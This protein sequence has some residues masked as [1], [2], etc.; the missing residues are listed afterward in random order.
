MRPTE[1]IEAWVA[2]FNAV[3]VDAA[4]DLYADDATLHVVFADKT[5]GKGA[6]RG[7][8]EMYFR[9]SDLYCE[10]RHLHAAGDTAVLEWVDRKGL[11]GCNVFRIADGQIIEQRNYFDQL[12]FFRKMGIPIPTE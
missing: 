6:I 11:P 4:L 12:T 9:A 3:D 2:A 5:E 8:F 1:V 7:L 10:V